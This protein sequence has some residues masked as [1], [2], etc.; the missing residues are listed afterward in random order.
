MSITQQKEAER[1]QA[2]LDEIDAQIEA[3]TLVVRRMTEEE[4]ERWNVAA[5]QAAMANNT[6]GKGR[7]RRRR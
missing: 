4:R 7:R 3:G 2:K 1:R 6:G 5:V